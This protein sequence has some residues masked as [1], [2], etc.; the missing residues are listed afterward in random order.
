MTADAL[1]VG[2]FN[3]PLETGLRA[4]FLLAAAA[5]M[6]LD[7]QRLVYCDYL[8]V[9]SGDVENGLPS[10]H[11]ATPHRAG[12]WL[13]RRE[14]L[15]AGLTL[16]IC[17]ELVEQRFADDGIT[18][19]ANSLTTPFLSH[20]HS[21]YGRLLKERAAWVS[22]HFAGHSNAMLERFMAENVG[23]WGAEFKRESILHGSAG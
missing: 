9:H 1:S 20:F 17:K 6:A 18:Y 22:A 16:M 13:V 12:E 3:S 14:T 19:A 23:R 4:L 2:P 21:E 5:P 15:K 7:L 11:P 10:L 8:L